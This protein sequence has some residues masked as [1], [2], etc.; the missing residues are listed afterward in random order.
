MVAVGSLVEEGVE[1]V[2]DMAVVPVV[3][4]LALFVVLERVEPLGMEG[5]L[6]HLLQNLNLGVEGS[7]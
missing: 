2:E 3:L 4:G 7:T 6:G 5:V 1:E